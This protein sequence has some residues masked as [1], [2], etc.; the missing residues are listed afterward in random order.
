MSSKTET[1]ISR[2]KCLIQLLRKVLRFRSKTS[3]EI[4]LLGSEKDVRKTICLVSTC[5]LYYPLCTTVQ[6]TF[7][8]ADRRSLTFMIAPLL[9]KE[10]FA[11]SVTT[12]ILIG[13]SNF[14]IVF[15][16]VGGFATNFIKTPM[17]WLRMAAISLLVIWVIVLY[18]PPTDKI[19][20]AFLLAPFFSPISFGCSAGNQALT[21]YIAKTT[22]LQKVNDDI[23]LFGAITS[24]L[25][26]CYLIVF[27]ILSIVLGRFIDSVNIRKSIL[28][29]G[30]IQFS[31]I[32]AI[33]LLNT[34]IPRG[35]LSLNPRRLSSG[36]LRNRKSGYNSIHIMNSEDPIE[37]RSLESKSNS[38]SHSRT[39][40]HAEI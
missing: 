14:G 34:L 19:G 24:F 11:M 18:Y 21:L 28:D 35:A 27:I 38:R 3:V 23:S 15:G 32:A 1:P 26:C 39:D 22:A 12:Q 29:V 25:Y 10:M 33:L 8:F 6:S 40:S 2:Y 16:V 7:S 5:K 17:P 9:A 20:Y 13:M 4:D 36:D 31:V 30:G 37:L